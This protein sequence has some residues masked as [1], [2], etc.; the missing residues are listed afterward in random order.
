MSNEKMRKLVRKHILA[1][2]FDSKSVMPQTGPGMPKPSSYKPG[3]FSTEADF[4]INRMVS[5]LG[6]GDSSRVKTAIQNMR[7]GKRTSTDN[8]VLAD[9]FTKIVD[10]L[11]T[12][13]VARSSILTFLSWIKQ[14]PVSSYP[15]E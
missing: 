9:L 3:T 11:A 13:S 8:A 15:G 14:M 7:M 5:V 4:D 1:E 6:Y 2:L 12:G 10:A